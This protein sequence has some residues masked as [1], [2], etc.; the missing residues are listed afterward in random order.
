MMTTAKM[1]RTAMIIKVK[2]KCNLGTP[3]ADLSSRF[4]V[5]GLDSP[6]PANDDLDTAE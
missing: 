4:L 1:V 3:S 6:I 2:L 5:G